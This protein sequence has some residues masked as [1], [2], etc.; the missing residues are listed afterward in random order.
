MV[1]HHRPTQPGFSFA[2]D[3]PGLDQ[4]SFHAGIGVKLDLVDIDLGYGFILM[5]DRTVTESDV[6]LI[7]VTKPER[8]DW[9]VIGNGDFSGH[10]HIV[11][12]S[13]NWHL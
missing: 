13:T 9:K 10:Y 5:S 1:F 11:G 6:R 8:D 2:V 7:D 3:F 4:Q 12:L